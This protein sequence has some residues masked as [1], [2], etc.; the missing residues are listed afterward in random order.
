LDKWQKPV[1]A[2][3]KHLTMLSKEQA[4]EHSKH[5]F[6]QAYWD[7]ATSSNPKSLHGHLSGTQW[8]PSSF[9]DV[10]LFR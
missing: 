10:C 1:L 8:N 4:K 2:N 7:Y 6:V 5:H 9:F 3:V